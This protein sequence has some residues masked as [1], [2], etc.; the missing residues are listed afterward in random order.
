MR[1]EMNE[2]ARDLW[3]KDL[4][5]GEYPQDT[6]G[7][8]VELGNGKVGHCCLAVLCRSAQKD[9]VPIRIEGEHLY[10][11]PC[12]DPDHRTGS[13]HTRDCV[14]RDD[15]HDDEWQEFYYGDLPAIVQVWA[16]LDSSNP[17]LGTN[18]TAIA[19]NDDVGA[20]FAEIA[21]LVKN[22]DGRD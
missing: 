20:S 16:G 22:G 19:L 4:L 3:V 14:Y 18:R 11:P 7:L 15:A 12:D 1:V 13:S 17:T 10:V 2:R 21:G 6:G 5:S 8:F 9:G